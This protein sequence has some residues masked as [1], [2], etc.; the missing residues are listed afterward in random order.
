MLLAGT[1]I[2]TVPGQASAVTTVGCG[3][4]IL[5]SVTL[6]AD[7]GPCATG[8]GIN[9]GKSGITLS[10][11]GHTITGNNTGNKTDNPQLGVNLMNVKNVTVQNGTITGFDAGVSITGGGGNTIQGLVVKNNI[12]HVL[13]TGGV[14]PKNPEATH[15]DFGDG[16]TT[17]NSNSN[18]IQ[19][20]EAF[21]NGPFS[22]IS[23]VDA[24]GYNKVL[25]NNAHDNNVSNI[26]PDGFTSGPCGP[27]GAVLVG[28]GRAH[29][30]VGIRVEGPGAT[31]NTV[32]ENR[33]TNNQLEGIAVH[34][35]TCHPP[36]PNF[37]PG[38]PNDS[39]LIR[40]NTVT[41]NGFVDTSDGIGIL[42]Q[43]PSGIVC[44][45]NNNT[46]TGNTSNGNGGNGIFVGGRNSTG[47]QVL[48]NTA[49]GNGVDGIHLNSGAHNA[50]IKRNKASGNGR[51]DGFDG[52][53]MPP[54]DANV[55]FLNTFAVVNQ[56]C[57]H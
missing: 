43:G 41:G 34:G 35:N 32:G 28:Q 2:A 16:I 36:N 9:I 29:Q 27:F 26:M 20:N 33:A 21:N 18:L 1:G 10:L 47:N 3:A 38:L 15:C 37:P 55:W 49:N 30:D 39:N 19:F 25:N 40:G 17:D 12:A 24:S 46:I 22:G 11:A 42:S 52:N 53:L 45:A 6:T 5:A 54:C 31:H 57:V 48:Q 44:V 50:S 56:P 4:V 51:Y 23:L 14:D 13:L 7:I 8:N